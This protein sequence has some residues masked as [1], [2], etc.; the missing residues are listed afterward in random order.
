MIQTTARQVNAIR[1]KLSRPFSGLDEKLWTYFVANILDRAADQGPYLEQLCRERVFCPGHLDPWLECQPI[2]PRK[3]TRGGENE[4]NTRIDL[5]IGAIRRREGTDGGIA[6][7]NS[8]R[9]PFRWAC[10]VE[11]KGPDRDC[12]FK[13]E[14]DWLRNQLERDIESLLSFQDHGTFPDRLYFTLLT[15]RLCRRHPRSR[16]YGY[17][18]EEYLKDSAL[19]IPDIIRCTIPVRDDGDQEYPLLPGRLERLKLT[20]LSY[21]DIFEQAFGLRDL[22]ILTPE[23]HGA[24]AGHIRNLA[25][26]LPQEPA[27]A[28]E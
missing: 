19:L 3:G 2:S 17:R 6:F 20:W 21:E 13:S 18:M 12:D 23:G 5:S 9:S 1:G 24:L 4:A 16:L 28:G 10:F 22:D 27:T 11:G 7:D 25:A 8:A 14:H 15:P 26:S